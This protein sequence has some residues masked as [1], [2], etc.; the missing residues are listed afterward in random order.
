MKVFVD[1]GF[2]WIG[3]TGFTA[4]EPATWNDRHAVSKLQV[5]VGRPIRGHGVTMDIA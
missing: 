5:R 3:T 4:M 2:T 1:C